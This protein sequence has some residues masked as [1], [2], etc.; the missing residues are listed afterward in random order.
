MSGFYIKELTIKGNS[1]SDA[2]V[3]FTK[4]LNVINGPSNT[5]KSFILQ[6]IN[7]VLGAES[8]KNIKQINGYEKIFLEIRDFD[9]DE[10]I[11]LI[12]MIKEKNIYFYL[13]TINEFNEKNIEELKQKHDPYKEDNISKFLLKRIGIDTN[14][15]LV[16][17]EKGQKKTLGFRGLANLSLISE[18][19]IISEVNSPVFN[20]EKVN[21]TYYKCLF[22]YLLTQKDDIKCE[23]IEDKKIRAVKLDAKIEYVNQEIE[24]LEINKKDIEG[25]LNELAEFKNINEY[26]QEVKTLEIIIKAKQKE[27]KEKIKKQDELN[28]KKNRVALLLDKFELL[29]NQY[30][31]DLK[32]LNFIQS[33]N[34]CLNQIKINYCPICNSKVNFNTE[35]IED[36]SLA[37][38]KESS[39][40]KKNLIDLKET[41]ESLILEK[42]SLDEKI[43]IYDNDV[44][45]LSDN[46]ASILNNKL[47]PLK[48]IIRD[49]IMISNLKDRKLQIEE[50]IINKKKDIIVFSEN[51]KEKQPKLNYELN[52]SDEVYRKFCTSIKNTLIDWKYT[53]VNEVKF[54]T[55][56]QDIIV[57]GEERLSNGKGYRAYFYAA[58][59]VTLMDYLLEKNYPYTRVLVLDSP[60]T[61]LKEEKIN[62]GNIEE[63]DMIEE[64]LQDSMFISL[65]KNCKNKQVIIIE[66]KEIPEEVEGKCNHIVFTKDKNYGRYG[67]IP[68]IQ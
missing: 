28:S 38:S 37:C 48:K 17:N 29:K 46:I 27:L 45:N 22:R 58:F 36:V 20:G 43:N 66:N 32:R 57:D 35:D 19:E 9:N 63:G 23:E 52:A 42:R 24:D 2:T 34:Q 64:S 54:D 1:V 62:K 44:T 39:K 21:N 68:I 14:K 15:F 4:G 51:K 61:T 40:T 49:T 65:A 53:S 60:L 8:L 67:F 6:C 55:K 7:Y 26:E 41:I 5:G 47:N 12:R 13:G 31:S 59:V 30:E 25:K 3:I 11:T 33:G 50:K 10:A 56:K 16:C 18:T